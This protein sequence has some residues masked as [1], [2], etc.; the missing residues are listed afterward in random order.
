MKLFILFASILLS[1]ICYAIH[2]P[3][4]N[5]PIVIDADELEYI[6]S[7]TDG[8]IIARN[9]VIARQDNQSVEANF[10]EYNFKKEVLIAEDKVKIIDKDGY[11]IDADKVILSN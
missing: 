6:G 10:I 2:N 9:N 4:D 11:I 7:Q 8:K 1:S 5:T 3:L